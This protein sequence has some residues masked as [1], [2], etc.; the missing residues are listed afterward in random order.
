MRNKIKHLKT[1]MIF[2][3]IFSVV[4]IKIPIVHASDINFYDRILQE[5]QGSP[6]TSTYI[7]PTPTATSTE[8]ETSEKYEVH[9]NGIQGNVYEILTGKSISEGEDSGEIH[10]PVQGI[11]V[12][13]GEQITYT[14]KYGNFSITFPVGTQKTTVPLKFI[15]G[16]FKETGATDDEKRNA[17][18]YNGHDYIVTEAPN[19]VDLPYKTGTDIEIYTS[20]GGC[21][22][23][24]IMVDCS[25][26]LRN[27]NITIEGVEKS[28]LSAIVDFTKSL[29]DTL[30]NSRRNIYIGLVFFA[31]NSYISRCLTKDANSLKAALDSICNS[32][33]GKLSNTNFTKAIKKAKEGF[34]YNGQDANRHIVI[35]SDNTPTAAEDVEIYFD[36]TVESMEYKL[37][38]IK[39]ETISA[40]EDIRNSGINIKSIY[41]D[42]KDSEQLEYIK[43]IFK[44]HVDILKRVDESTIL[45][46]D[47]ALASK[48]I[49]E[50]TESEY[51]D[52]INIPK[53]LENDD[54]RA[55]V[56]GKFNKL[57]SYNSESEEYAKTK[58]FE[59]INKE[60]TFN[61]SE[62]DNLQDLTHM[63]IDCG[64]YEI[65]Y[66]KDYPLQETVMVQQEI[67]DPAYP[68]NPEKKIIE[69]KEVTV[70]HVIEQHEA[71]LGL[72]SRPA[73]D[74]ELKSAITG[75]KTVAAKGMKLSEQTKDGLNMDLIKLEIDQELTYGTAVDIEY[76][77]EISNVSALQCNELELIGYLPERFGMDKN[78]NFITTTGNNS[79]YNWEKHNVGELYNNGF[80]SEAEYEKHKHQTAIIA[81]MKNNG[82]SD[83]FFI[84]PGG[85]RQIKVVITTTLGGDLDVFDNTDFKMDVEVLS[86]K[87]NGGSTHRRMA[88]IGKTTMLEGTSAYEYT[89]LM[90][91]FP[92]NGAE[93]DHFKTMNDF[94]ITPPLGMDKRNIIGYII[95]TMC[96]LP[97]I[98]YGIYII[99]KRK[100]EVK[101]E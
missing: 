67:Q 1:L 4:N 50:T 66:E 73:I 56:D 58:V 21:E 5:C 95:S 32:D 42:P 69:E 83:S 54:R 92:G 49:E 18:K 96:I 14:D 59:L 94:T 29:I 101:N 48:L 40:L 53:G 61:Q 7:E 31:D 34:V 25:E 60:T 84:A 63:V 89:Y 19:Q 16:S 36:D 85:V 9:Y 100:L 65:E 37:D 26:S 27:E 72:A 76:T 22:Q 23:V 90:G 88:T 98:V 33:W 8:S 11:R 99:I 93:N 10:L 81:H 20:K 55:E 12:E 17:L 91:M 13:A 70:Y 44:N 35:L 38:Q 47:D 43:N 87:D 64:D 15:Y 41:I 39:E 3:L 79:L 28:K 30:L 78:S 75:E 74:I 52:S 24:M 77:I 46:I 82:S 2:I 6:G 68:D 71:Y 57:F 62:A 51:R 86:Y 80:I 97:I 45:T